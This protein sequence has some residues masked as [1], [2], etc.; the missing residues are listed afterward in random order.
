MRG[1]WGEYLKQGD[2]LWDTWTLQYHQLGKFIVCDVHYM[3]KFVWAEQDIFI[4]QIYVANVFLVLDYMRFKFIIILVLFSFSIFFSKVLTTSGQL[5]DYKQ[6]VGSFIEIP[7]Q[8]WLAA[9]SRIFPAVSSLL[10]LVTPV[11][12]IN[13]F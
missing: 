3:F 1:G 6:V 10:Q 8:G 4:P 11:D 2:L 9:N 5:Q 7:Q 12:V 13:I